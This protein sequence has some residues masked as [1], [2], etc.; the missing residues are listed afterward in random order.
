MSQHRRVS[1]SK[2]H[3]A[4]LARGETLVTIDLTRPDG[5]RTTFQGGVRG[6]RA[7]EVEKLAEAIWS[8]IGRRRVAQTGKG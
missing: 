5:S 3:R 6:D 4:R 2:D 7:G 8:L 1:Y